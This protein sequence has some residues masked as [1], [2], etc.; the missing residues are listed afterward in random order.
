MP[1]RSQVRK[2]ESS[3]SKRNG[4]KSVYGCIVEVVGAIVEGGA[5]RILYITLHR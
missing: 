2:K 5:C 4:L 3:L 1:L